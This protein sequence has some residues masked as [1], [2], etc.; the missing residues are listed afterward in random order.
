[1]KKGESKA[2]NPGRDGGGKWHTSIDHPHGLENNGK[3]RD[4]WE[5]SKRKM[6]VDLWASKRSTTRTQGFG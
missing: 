1:M 2:G 3:K 4:L 6:G 5:W